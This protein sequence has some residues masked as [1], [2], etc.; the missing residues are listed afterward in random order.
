[1]AEALVVATDSSSTVI[2]NNLN[3][4]E[5]HLNAFEALFGIKNEPLTLP[6]VSV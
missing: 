4:T 2:S 1:M 5:P 6:S 3:S